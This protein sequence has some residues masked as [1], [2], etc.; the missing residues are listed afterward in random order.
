MILALFVIP[1]V[2]AV[3]EFEKLDWG[4]VKQ[5]QMEELEVVK[6]VLE[7]CDNALFMG[8][9]CSEF[10]LGPQI[11]AEIP[12]VKPVNLHVSKFGMEKSVDEYGDFNE[13][14]NKADC[15]IM[16]ELS[17]RMV[18]TEEM[19]SLDEKVLDYMENIGTASLTILKKQRILQRYSLLLLFLWPVLG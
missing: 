8:G 5:N 4:K 15:I 6:M 12:H 16:G 3:R 1:T 9:E 10:D 19:I 7:D 2:L 14:V 18:F 17:L 13:V 11:F